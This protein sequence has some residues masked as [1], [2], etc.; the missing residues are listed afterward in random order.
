MQLVW[1]NELTMWLVLTMV[2]E[3]TAIRRTEYICYYLQEQNIKRHNDCEILYSSYRR[4][5]P[6]NSNPSGSA[7]CARTSS[8]AIAR[9]TMGPVEFSTFYRYAWLACWPSSRVGH[10]RNT[11]PSMLTGDQGP[12]T[13]LTGETTFLSR[14][15]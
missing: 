6:P 7:F 8:S 15:D 10:A 1:L 11:S 5:F 9:S 2:P 14:N 12:F 4:S 13:A 3:S